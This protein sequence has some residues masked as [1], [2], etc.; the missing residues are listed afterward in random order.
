MPCAVTP[1]RGASQGRVFAPSNPSSLRSWARRPDAFKCAGI[2]VQVRRNR[3]SSPI[4]IG[5]RVP[6]ESA[7]KWLRNTHD[8]PAEVVGRRPPQT[9]GSRRHAGITR[10]ALHS[11]D[12]TRK[13]LRLHD[14]RGTGLTWMATRGE[15]PLKIQ[16]RTGHRI[17]EM[18][19][20]NPH[21]RSSR[22]GHP[23]SLPAALGASPLDDIVENIVRATRTV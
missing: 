19:K 14:L 9:S 21:R 5:A 7:F 12:D 23:R 6:S 18:T 4:G 10:E 16:Q 15:D 1:L 8:A 11:T 2:G 17:F 13:R 22:S 3:R 20:V